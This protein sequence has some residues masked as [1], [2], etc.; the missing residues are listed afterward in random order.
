MLKRL[1]WGHTFMTSKQYSQLL[2]TSLVGY[3]LNLNSP[4]HAA[5]KFCNPPPLNVYSKSDQLRELICHTKYSSVYA[6]H[7]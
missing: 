1:V 5:S 6:E 7:K 4:S 3:G 2:K